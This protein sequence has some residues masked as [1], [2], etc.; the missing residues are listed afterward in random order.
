MKKTTN[1]TILREIDVHKM[2]SANSELLRTYGSM[3]T[4]KQYRKHHRPGKTEGHRCQRRCP[5][6]CI[7]QVEKEQRDR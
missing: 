1:E 6:R 2:L 3:L 4:E 7:G 5:V